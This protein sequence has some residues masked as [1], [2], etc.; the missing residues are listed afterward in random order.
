MAYGLP[1][2]SP[3]KWNLRGRGLGNFYDPDNWLSPILLDEIMD[4]S[5]ALRQDLL[6]LLCEFK[7]TIFYFWQV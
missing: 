7:T 2:W 5:Q 6:A 1:A 3:V 4:V